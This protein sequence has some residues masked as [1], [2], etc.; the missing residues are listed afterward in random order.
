M[1]PKHIEIADCVVSILTDLNLDEIATLC[2]VLIDEVD[3]G[4]LDEFDHPAILLLFEDDEQTPVERIDDEADVEDVLLVG[5][6]RHHGIQILGKQLVGFVDDEPMQFLRRILRQ[7][8]WIIIDV[9]ADDTD[10][11][12][13]VH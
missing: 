4:T 12:N 6:P 5:F 3:L 11:V 13:V 2:K 8:P 1:V 7:H 10:T 9:G